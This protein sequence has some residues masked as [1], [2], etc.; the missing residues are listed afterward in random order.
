M[1]NF[2]DLEKIK[3]CSQ[4]LQELDT[5]RL[6]L[7]F[8]IG[9]DK[10]QQDDIFLE[11]TKDDFTLFEH[12]ELFALLKDMYCK[13]KEINFLT[14]AKEMKYLAYSKPSRSEIADYIQKAHSVKYVKGVIQ[15]LQKCTLN[16]S[17]LDT[18]KTAS[19]QWKSGIDCEE[20]S[21][22]LM[23]L[24][25]NILLR[26]TTEKI[27]SFSQ[28]IEKLQNRIEKNRELGIVTGMLYTNLPSLD[29]KI[30]GFEKGDLCVIGA[31]SG[32]GKSALGL[33]ISTLFAK[34]GICGTYYSSEMR[35]EALVSRI[36]SAEINDAT[37]YSNSFRK[38]VLNNRQYDLFLQKKEQLGDLPLYFDDNNRVNID[39]IVK[40]IRIMKRRFNIQYAFVDYLQMLG[41]NEKNQQYNNEIFLGLTVRKLK[42]VADEEG[43]VVFLLSQLNRDNNNVGLNEIRLRGSGQ[44]KETASE[45]I[46]ME[47]NSDDVEYFQEK[48]FTE[49]KCRDR[50]LLKVIKNRDGEAGYY[51]LL[52]FDAPHARFYDLIE[53]QQETEIPVLKNEITTNAEP[54]K[55]SANSMF[56]IQAKQSESDC[57]F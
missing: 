49:T 16:R 13:Q 17:F 25:S 46:L 39:A 56:E 32:A 45:V 31:N 41:A 47:R 10:E 55:L 30:K 9:Y 15:I 53:E 27:T 48:G 26:T 50:A 52:G 38:Q 33:T 24:L 4:G 23:Q 18:I 40:S 34:Q 14:V 37:L 2:Q 44:I 6:A 21:Q 57:P 42:N 22:N 7:G 19:E 35:D 28:A 29:E 12:R 36:L 3:Q 54:L 20:I 51:V 43:I 5:E 11:L 8:I 1:E